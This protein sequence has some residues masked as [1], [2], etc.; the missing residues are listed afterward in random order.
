MGVHLFGQLN[1]ANASLYQLS[2]IATLLLEGKDVLDAERTITV[3]I[4]KNDGNRILAGSFRRRVDIVYQGSSGEVYREVKTY[5]AERGGKSLILSNRF[6]AWDTFGQ[7][8]TFPGKEYFLDHV[9][10]GP[11]DPDKVIEWRFDSFNTKDKEC[12]GTV[13][14]LVDRDLNNVIKKLGL[15]PKWVKTPHTKAMF[16][17][18]RSTYREAYSNKTN[19]IL[20]RNSLWENSLNKLE[21]Y[22]PGNLDEITQALT[23]L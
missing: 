9:I 20:K 1:N 16:S 5:A 17:M 18:N 23:E 4:Y 19:V 6:T 10:A 3:P 12:G 2:Q 14:G 21:P 13:K 15:L 11:T 8:G 22:L 7:K